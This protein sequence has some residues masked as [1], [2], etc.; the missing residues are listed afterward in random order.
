[1]A[2]HDLILY[3]A[4]SLL[5]GYVA[6]FLTV[7]I[8]HA[9]VILLG[10]LWSSGNAQRR[11]ILVGV[12]AIIVFGSILFYQ[13]NFVFAVIFTFAFAVLFL[14]GIIHAIYR[15]NQY[16]PILKA[17]IQSLFPKED[18]DNDDNL[19]DDTLKISLN[20]LGSMR[21]SQLESLKILFVFF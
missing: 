10:K 15:F 7:K 18:S 12:I 4:S 11:Y 19:L 2:T 16:E 21:K 1:M 14:V 20:M 5:F 6:G 13:T 9:L 17:S 3:L 8:N